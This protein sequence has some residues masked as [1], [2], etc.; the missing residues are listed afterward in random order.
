MVGFMFQATIFFPQDTNS[1]Y[2]ATVWLDLP[3]ITSKKFKKISKK[4][5]LYCSSTTSAM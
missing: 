2:Q 4:M 1:I 3:A 5:I